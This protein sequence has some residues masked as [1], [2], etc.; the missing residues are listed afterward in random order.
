M[1][2]LGVVKILG[3]KDIIEY[4]RDNTYHMDNRD[5]GDDKGPR[6][7]IQILVTY[8][9]VPIAFKHVSRNI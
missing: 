5:H 7:S 6:D 1:M 9:F 8:T 3:I 4:L 2:I